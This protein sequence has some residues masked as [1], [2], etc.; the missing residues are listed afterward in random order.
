MPYY[1]FE[2]TE[3]PRRAKYMEEHDGFQDAKKS[4][5]AMREANENE[6]LQYRIMHGKTQAEAERLVLTPPKKPMVYGEE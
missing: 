4:V 3:R 5:R 6:L 2:F 1:I